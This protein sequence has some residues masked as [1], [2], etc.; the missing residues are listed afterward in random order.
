M[1]CLVLLKWMDAHYVIVG[2]YTG[3]FRIKDGRLAPLRTDSFLVPPTYKDV[4]I[5]RSA[6][7]S[8]RKA[9]AGFRVF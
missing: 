5:A 3:A 4:P 6:P 7:G 8:L 2:S 9:P 1:E